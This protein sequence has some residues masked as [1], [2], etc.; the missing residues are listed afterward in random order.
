MIYT[1]ENNEFKIGIGYSLDKD[2][3]NIILKGQ[4]NKLLI[5][6]NLIVDGEIAIITEG[7]NNK[8]FIGD[9]FKIKGRLII[10]INGN[11][12]DVHLGHNIEVTNFLK[13]DVGN[14]SEDCV[15][16]IGDSATLCKTNFIENGK[17]NE[18][19]IGENLKNKDQ[20]TIQM[21]GDNNKTKLGNN[22]EIVEYVFFNM[23]EKSKNRYIEIGDFTSF[24]KTNIQNYDLNSSL[25]IGKDCMFS[26][27]TTVYNNDGHAIFQDGKLINQAKTCKIG[28]HVWVGWSAT[29]MKNCTIPNGTIIARNALVCKKF[30]KQNTII[31]GVPAK[32]VKENIE[33][34]RQ[35][36]NDVLNL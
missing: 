10:I 14:G 1:N 3:V 17:G 12:N 35:T 25:I 31:A 24:Y 7:D 21:I 36:I 26:Y 23:G 8:I 33:W 13:I 6:D 27:D 5:G 11:N 34:S 19:L 16:K 20:M 28:D 4:G 29:I 30:K 22:I 2:K 9:N 18:L 15:V 32:I